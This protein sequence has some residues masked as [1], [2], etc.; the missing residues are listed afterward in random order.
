MT[1]EEQRAV[2]KILHENAR[3]LAKLRADYDPITGEGSVGKRVKLKLEDYRI[4]VQYIPVEMAEVPL[5]KELMQAG[6][7]AKF[8]LTHPWQK[9][10][11]T[12]QA[13]A[14]KIADLREQ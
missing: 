8:I 10:P 6:S 1:R 11:P 2:S 4:P 7:I 14:D 12:A 9:K 13:V 3:R 5:I